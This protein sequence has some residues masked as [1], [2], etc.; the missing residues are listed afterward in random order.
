LEA[1]TSHT[2][3]E[4]S[5]KE[6]SKAER[7]ALGERKLKIIEDIDMDGSKEVYLSTQNITCTI[8]PS[9]GG[10]IREISFHPCEHNLVD[11][12]SRRREHYHMLKEIESEKGKDIAQ[13]SIATIHER[14]YKIEAEELVFDEH[15]RSF[16]YEEIS[17]DNGKSWINLINERF[18]IVEDN[19][20][21]FEVEFKKTFPNLGKIDLKKR[22]V[23]LDNGLKIIYLFDGD[24]SPRLKMLFNI[25]LTS[26]ESNYA[27]LKFSER[28]FHLGENLA[29][30]GESFEIEDKI[31]SLKILVSADFPFQAKLSPIYTLSQSENGFDRIYQATEIA[32]SPLEDKNDLTI[33]VKLTKA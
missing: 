22:I 5:F 4:A 27:L 16:G 23:L 3:E 31:S 26:I 2:L 13:D 33:H 19:E 8:K 25:K 10:S 6:L 15:E 29:I 30:Q 12:L 1:Y 32:I 24:P 20:T 9:L 21:A 11:T 14:I 17:F 28:S 18:E 7:L